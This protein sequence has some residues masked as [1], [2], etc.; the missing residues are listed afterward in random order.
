MNVI[1][2]KSKLRIIAAICMVLVC[3][4]VTGCVATGPNA[5]EEPEAK[6]TV[7]LPAT[8]KYA[9]EYKISNRETGHLSI[10]RQYSYD[11]AGRCIRCEEAIE[12]EERGHLENTY[13][14]AYDEKGNLI[15]ESLHQKGQKG[16]R[17]WEGGSTYTLHYTYDKYGRAEQCELEAMSADNELLRNATYRFA[18][19]AQGNLETLTV[20]DETWYYYSYDEQ[21]KMIAETYCHLL[22]ESDPNADTYKY[23]NF[24]TVYQ[25]N[26]QG[27]VASVYSQY[28]YSVENVG[29]DGLDQL[30]FKFNAN[31][32]TFHYD[33]G[34]NLIR[35]NLSAGTEVGQQKY[36]ENGQWIPE[37]KHETIKYRG[38]EIDRLL[39]KYTQD[40]YGNIVKFENYQYTEAYTYTARELTPTQQKRAEQFFIYPT[41]IGDGCRL[42]GYVFAYFYPTWYDQV[43]DFKYFVNFYQN[44]PW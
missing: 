11:E 22:P 25:R 3:A 6:Q 8:Y 21:G 43:T 33:E 34:G 40:E 9:G 2:K 17:E 35:Y 18:Y 15:S 29:A 42:P 24:Q 38:E 12:S 19:D 36:D 28:A 30:E 13:Q 31:S 27:K 26:T 1:V 44:L 41:Y 23:L 20:N 10:E 14:F 7:Y 4:I 16:G 5:K 39:A 37:E 32:Y